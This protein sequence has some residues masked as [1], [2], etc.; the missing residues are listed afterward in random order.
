MQLES[1]FEPPHQA[2]LDDAAVVVHLRDA[3]E[4]EF[5]LGFFHHGESFRKRL[6]HP[7]FDAVVDHLHEVA[8]SV[9]GEK[10]ISIAAREVSKKRLAFSERRFVASYH[11]TPSLAR[12]ARA[13]GEADIDVVNAELCEFS[14][15]LYRIFEV[16]VAA[17]DN[18]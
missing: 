6:H 16:R 15:T 1:I 12:A 3:R 8:G 10:F 9:T 2:R 18:Y 11:Q 17:V 13:A 14:R 4:V 7:V 5:V